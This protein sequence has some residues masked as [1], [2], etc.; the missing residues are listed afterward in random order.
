MMVGS[1]DGLEGL[2]GQIDLVG[3][4]GMIRL[5]GFTDGLGSLDPLLEQTAWF[6]SLVPSHGAT[7]LRRNSAKIIPRRKVGGGLCGQT[8]R[9]TSANRLFE[10]I[11]RTDFASRRQSKLVQFCGVGFLP[12]PRIIVK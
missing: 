10:R 12:W 8:F 5:I 9:A 2:T 3:L 6:E 1:N 4:T 11:L 7:H